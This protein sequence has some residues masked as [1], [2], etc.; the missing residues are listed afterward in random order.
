MDTCEFCDTCSFFK[1]EF[2]DNQ[3]TNKY[4]C[5]TYCDGHFI[6][7]ARYKIAMSQGMRN[8]P[9]D[10]LPDP[11]ACLKCFADCDSWN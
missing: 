4:L 7:C 2:Q 10:L 1:K 8:V 6:S 9:P 11:L 3:D 5:S